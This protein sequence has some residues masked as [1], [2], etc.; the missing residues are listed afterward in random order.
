[1]KVDFTYGEQNLQKGPWMMNFLNN[2]ERKFGRYAIPHLT[3]YIILTYVAGYMLYFIGAANQ[4]DV[5]QFLALSPALI[6]RGQ[7]WRLVSWWL[8]PPSGVDVFTLIMLFVYYQL[9]SVL[10]RTWG[11][12]FYNVYIFM[13]LVFTVAG[14]FVLYAFTGIDVGLTRIFFSTYYIS[15]SIFLGF[16]MTF[17]EQQMLFMFL[18][19]VRIK[20]FAIL[21]IVYL[22]YDVIAYW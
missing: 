20:W 16:A 11:D 22:C 17:P 12:F 18:I 15:L 8:I 3:M 10:E 13:G 5:R 7:V 2:M 21:D 19:P 4:V 1:M 6:L 9:G 14:A